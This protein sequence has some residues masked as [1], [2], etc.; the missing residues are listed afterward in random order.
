M[1]SL[2]SACLQSGG[3]GLVERHSRLASR[4]GAHPDPLNRAFVAAVSCCGFASEAEAS[5]KARSR[6]RVF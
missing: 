1:T 5:C 3:V 6:V 2:L 4:E